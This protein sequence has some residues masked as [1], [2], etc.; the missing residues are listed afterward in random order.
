MS[1]LIL[2]RPSAWILTILGAVE[3]LRD[4]PSVPPEDCLG[5]H[6]IGHLLERLLAELLSD[7]GQRSPLAIRQPQAPSDLISKNAVLGSEILV[8]QQELLIH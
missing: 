5:S 8:T 6:D 7:L 1:E 4:E 3:F 2:G